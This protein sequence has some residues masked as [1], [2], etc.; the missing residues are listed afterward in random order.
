MP[1]NVRTSAARVIRYIGKY[2]TIS[3]NNDTHS[4]I[5]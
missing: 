2:D 4:G 5:R 3:G 1:A